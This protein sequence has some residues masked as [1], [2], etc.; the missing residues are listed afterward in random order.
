MNNLSM[1]ARIS[2]EKLNKLNNKFHSLYKKIE[3]ID[4]VEDVNEE[5]NI[6]EI[7]HVDK[8]CFNSHFET[9]Y[10]FEKETSIGIFEVI[11]E[12]SKSILLSKSAIKQFL[13]Y[14]FIPANKNWVRKGVSYR[15]IATLCNVSIPTVKK[16]H[17]VLELL[18]FVYSTSAGHGKIDIVI[19][20]EYKNHYSKK[21]GGNGYVTMSIDTLKHLLSF[22]SINEL[23][24]EIKK[25]LWIDASKGSIGKRVKFNKENLTKMLPDYIRKSKKLTE[26]ILNN[27]HTLFHI[28]KG[29]LDVTNYETKDKLRNRL[30]DIVKE[31]V[32][33]LF[34]DSKASFSQNYSKLLGKINT[35]SYNY[36][37]EKNELI[38]NM[39]LEK[40]LIIDDISKLGLQ[41]G[42]E[43]VISTIKYMFSNYCFTDEDLQCTVNEIYNP[44]GFIRNLISNMINKNGSLNKIEL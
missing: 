8:D 9:Y 26:Q 37:F 38:R 7:M 33:K 29:S 13:L 23:K 12:E 4:N 11:S 25:I 39:E 44:G 31:Q 16:N 24:T 27:K 34:E 43:K 6:D 35:S 3:I 18:G 30:K 10:A 2:K 32:M 40:V 42:L 36:E 21:K 1:I 17:K 20:E 5:F 15:E 22:T 19:D 14:H 28:A 41:Y